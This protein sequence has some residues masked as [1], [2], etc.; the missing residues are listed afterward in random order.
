M[1]STK[2]IVDTLRPTQLSLVSCPVLYELSS[3]FISP[4][5]PEKGDTWGVHLYLA[6]YTQSGHLH[7]GHSWRIKDEQ[8]NDVHLAK[9]ARMHCDLREMQIQRVLPRRVLPSEDPEMDIQNDWRLFALNPR[10][11]TRM[12]HQCPEDHLANGEDEMAVKLSPPA[13]RT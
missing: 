11:Y 9:E 12:R 2:R 5:L 13:G 7:S 1:N 3:C 6:G 8:A 4:P 10:T